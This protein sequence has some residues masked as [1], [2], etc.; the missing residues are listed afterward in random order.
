[1]TRQLHLLPQILKKKDIN[2]IVCNRHSKREMSNILRIVLVLKYEAIHIITCNEFDWHRNKKAQYWA[3]AIGHVNNIPTMQ[4]YNGI[5]RNTR[6]KSYML[7]LT[8]SGNSKIMH[9]GILIN[10][11]YK[12][13]YQIFMTHL[14]I[15]LLNLL[16]ACWGAA[17]MQQDN[18]SYVD[19]NHKINEAG[20]FYKMRSYWKFTKS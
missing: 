11:P 2:I 16:S 13:E 6:S 9:C 1:M 14:S 8:E 15:W 7:S 3:V 19:Q 5:S 4:F 10:M 12:W 17:T 18:S 20:N